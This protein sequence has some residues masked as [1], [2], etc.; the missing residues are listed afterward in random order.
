M[1]L[2]VDTLRTGAPKRSGAW[3]L[4]RPPAHIRR[5]SVTGGRKP[6]LAGCPSRPSSPAGLASRK[7][8][9]CHSGGS[10][11]PS[12]RCGIRPRVD[13]IKRAGSVRRVSACSSL[14]PSQSLT[15]DTIGL[16]RVVLNEFSADPG[17]ISADG[18][19]LRD[20][21]L[22]FAA[23]MRLVVRSPHEIANQSGLIEQLA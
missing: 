21:I 6:P 20:D 12:D 14:R 7:Y 11:S 1:L 17:R 22:R 4:N 8:N 18:G 19:C 13:C 10:S 15:S 5:G 2:I 16:L 23:K 3:K 9:Q